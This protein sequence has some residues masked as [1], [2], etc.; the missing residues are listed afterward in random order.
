MI[1]RSELFENEEQ[2]DAY[3]TRL[4]F[5]RKPNETGPFKLRGIKQW[6]K[7]SAKAGV[8]EQKQPYGWLVFIRD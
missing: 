8:R 4:G 1:D 3:L 5:I 6:I 2:A 7:G